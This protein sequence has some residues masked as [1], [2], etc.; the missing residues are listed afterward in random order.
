MRSWRS[1]AVACGAAAVAVALTALIPILQE[2]STFLMSFL[3][4]V[5]TAWTFGWRVGATATVFGAA[6]AAIFLLPGGGSLVADT[7]SSLFRLFTFAVAA[8]VVLMLARAR[9][10]AY[11]RARQTEELY[12]LVVDNGPV[13]VAGADDHGRTVVFNRACEQLTGYSRLE[14]LGKPFV[15]T[16]VP[17][18]WRERVGARFRDEP[19]ERLALPH[20]NPWRTKGGTERLIEWRCFRV[21]SPDGSPLTV[22]I[23]QDVTEQEQ[24][25]HQLRESLHRE[26]E[27]LA[28]SQAANQQKERFI[29]VL[30]HELRGLLNAAR[31][32]LQVWTTESDRV[33]PRLLAVDRNLQMMQGLIEDV[34]DFSRVELGKLTLRRTAIELRPWLQDLLASARTL[35]DA[36]HILLDENIATD[37]PTIEAD[38]KRLQQIVLNV[39]GNAIKFTP[40]NGH[41]VVSASR[42]SSGAIQLSITD[43]GPGISSEQRERVFEAFWQGDG[44]RG[45][46]LGLGLALVQR[47]VQAHGGEVSI[48]IGPTGRGTEVSVILP[49]GAS[50]DTTEVAV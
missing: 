19:M 6:L 10:L 35:A 32:W 8:G 48:S 13:L 43:D 22:G 29:A 36:R 31:G 44:P 1:H 34:V 21:T 49:I 45:D 7:G 30:S 27:A 15:E 46:G 3:V 20:Q 23:G 26:S 14:V 4:V 50:E 28:N 16:F 33:S 39:L 40:Q 25:Q 41:V 12:R 24:V 17:V 38:P 18:T 47:L 5:L 11:E 2:R 42:L 37:L 9:E